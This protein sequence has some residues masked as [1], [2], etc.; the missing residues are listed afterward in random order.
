MSTTQRDIADPVFR[1]SAITRRRS[2]MKHPTDKTNAISLAMDLTRPV[3]DETRSVADF[4]AAHIERLRA[5]VAARI[6][7]FG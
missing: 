7:K 4:T 6:E 5:D 3:N 2:P 1:R